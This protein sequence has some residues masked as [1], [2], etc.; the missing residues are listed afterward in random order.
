M[1]DLGPD[2]AERAAHGRR[3][4]S[5]RDIFL[6][7]GTIFVAQSAAVVGP[8]RRHRGLIFS[9]AALPRLGYVRRPPRGRG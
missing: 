6:S 1:A 2:R 3:A 4:S 9:L 8:V 5:A 7:S